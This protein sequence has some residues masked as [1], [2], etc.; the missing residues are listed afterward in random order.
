MTCEWKSGGNIKLLEEVYN[1]EL[2]KAEVSH[3]KLVTVSLYNVHSWWE[4]AKSH[5]PPICEFRTNYSMAESEESKKRYGGRI[6][7]QAFPHYDASVQRVYKE[8]FLNKSDFIIPLQ[9][10]NQLIKGGSFSSSHCIRPDRMNSNRDEVVIALRKNGFRVDGLGNCLKGI[11][12]TERI[13]LPPLG[14]DDEEN[15]RI[16]RRIIA[17]YMFHMAFENAIEP[18]YVTEKVFD[19]LLAGTVPVYLGDATHCKRLLP[20]PKAAIFLEDF[21]NDVLQL[22]TYLK[23]LT[24]NETAYEEHRSWHRS[25]NEEKHRSRDLLLHESWSCRICE[26]ALDSSTK[27]GRKAE[28]LASKRCGSSNY[29]SK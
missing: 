29:Y 16:K 11:H 9:P 25:F 27:K 2:K 21:N 14:N 15:L 4:N 18:G 23:Y 13:Y 26:W 19:S 3:T 28:I 6:F 12:G 24:K 7:D 22:A 10:Y 1:N 17:K 5:L 8:A 20:H